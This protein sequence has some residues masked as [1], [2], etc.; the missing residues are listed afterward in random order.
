VVQN[1]VIM[2]GFEYSIC[3]QASIPLISKNKF[4]RP[5]YSH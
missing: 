1:R 5:E 2:Q 3:I 4:D